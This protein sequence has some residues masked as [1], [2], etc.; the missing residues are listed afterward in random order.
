MTV[1]I[2]M[3]TLKISHNS[4]FYLFSV[5]LSFQ[6]YFLAIIWLAVF[7]K[8]TE[9]LSP[10]NLTYS[11]I[12]YIGFLISHLSSFLFC[13]IYLLI[14]LLLWCITCLTSYSKRLKFKFFICSFCKM[15]FVHVIHILPKFRVLGWKPCYWKV[16]WLCVLS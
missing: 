5:V 12:L 1:S 10:W 16:N 11:I 3:H 8:S 7:I 15:S 2:P 14:T 9:Y 6:P 13:S 4:S